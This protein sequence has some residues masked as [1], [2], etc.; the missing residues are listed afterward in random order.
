M[1]VLLNVC[2]RNSG[3]D[4]LLNEG[5]KETFPES[6]KEPNISREY[7]VNPLSI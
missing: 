4:A 5:G 7:S 3:Y 6:G 2:Q 1:Q